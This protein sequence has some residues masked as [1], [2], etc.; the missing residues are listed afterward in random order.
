MAELK[1][2]NTEQVAI[3]DDTLVERLSKYRWHLDTGQGYVRTSSYLRSR[4][5]LHTFIMRMVYL[6]K[7]RI[8]HINGNKLDNRLVNLRFASAS[9][10]QHNK[11][12]S[13][14]RKTSSK[15]KCVYFHTAS[16]RWLV[17]VAL[18]GIRYTNGSHLTEEDARIAAN[19]LMQKLHGPF[20]KLNERI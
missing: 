4:T 9:Q 18:N 17:S 3:V 8:D 6:K 7:D 16:Q 5:F 12:K 14:T 11:V 15:Y 2:T 1:L 10:N 13:K 19:N 20:A